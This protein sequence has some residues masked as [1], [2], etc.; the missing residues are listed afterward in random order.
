MGTSVFNCPTLPPHIS[1]MSQTTICKVQNNLLTSPYLTV[2][3]KRRSGRHERFCQQK[4]NNRATIIKS[5][6]ITTAMEKEVVGPTCR[7]KN[8]DVEVHWARTRSEKADHPSYHY[9]HFRA[10]EEYYSRSWCMIVVSGWIHRKS[11]SRGRRQRD[12]NES[13]GQDTPKRRGRDASKGSRV[14]AD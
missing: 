1:K 13:P 5:T 9:S 14:K 4:I 6:T 8:D 7:S 11:I 2:S 3:K 12:E 10:L